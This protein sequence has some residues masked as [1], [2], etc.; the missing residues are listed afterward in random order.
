MALDTM[1][2]VSLLL[3]LLPQRWWQYQGQTSIYQTEYRDPRER[4]VLVCPLL[5]MTATTGPET[6]R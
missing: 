2:S 1:P 4:P 5:D 3:T 6:E